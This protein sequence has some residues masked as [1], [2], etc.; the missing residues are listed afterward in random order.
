MYHVAL[1]PHRQTAFIMGPAARILKA[2][3]PLQNGPDY[4]AKAERH[5]D[6]LNGKIYW[7]DDMNAP[8]DTPTVKV[9]G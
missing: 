7:L 8:I 5:V 6:A 3:T 9:G 1:D 2:Y 4:V